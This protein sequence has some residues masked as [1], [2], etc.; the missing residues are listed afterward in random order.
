MED[1]DLPAVDEAIVAARAEACLTQQLCANLVYPGI[2]RWQ[3]LEAG[4]S[5]MPPATW[6]IFLL[7]S[8]Y[9]FEVRP[10]LL[11]LSEFMNSPVLAI[12]QPS[13]QPKV[14]Q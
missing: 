6:E 9:P 14:D 3:S 8:R 12:D 10:L 13:Q 1:D 4:D 2:R 5:R 11:R 7:K